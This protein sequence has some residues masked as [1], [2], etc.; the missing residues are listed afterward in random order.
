MI[1]D[2]P[3]I[4]LFKTHDNYYIYDVNT[5]MILSIQKDTYKYLIENKDK[6]YTSDI[7]INKEV[8][9]LLSKGFLSNKHASK[10]EHPTSELLEYYLNNRLNTITLQVTQQCNLRCSYCAYSGTYENRIH[11]DKSMNI[12]VARKGI[13][14]LVNNSSESPKIS[15]GFYGGEPL[16]RADF[17]KECV[18]YA[19][20]Q[21]EGK[22]VTFHMTTN[23]TLLSENIIDFLVENNFS[24]LISLDGPEEMHD[25]NR[26]FAANGKGTFKSIVNNIERFNKKYPEYAKKKISFNAVLDGCTDIKCMSGFLNDFDAIKDL[27]WNASLVTSQYSKQKID[28]QESYRIQSKYERF[29][30]LLYMIG[31]LPQKDVLRIFDRE[32]ARLSDS[33][34]SRSLTRSLS[35]KIHHGGPCI[36]GVRKLF[37]D[38]N[39]T[40]YPCERVSELSDVMKIGSINEGFNLEK[41]KRILNIGKLTEESCKDCWAFRFCYLCAT[42]A[43][44]GTE[45]SKEKKLANCNSVRFNAEEE[46]KNYCTLTEFGYNFEKASI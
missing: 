29:K 15:V 10:I 25:K 36:P 8:Q 46:L 37:M 30:Y 11:N 24:L 14:I 28:I 21:S 27:R 7:S 41:I 19:K 35:E 6:L 3:F 1:K 39:G 2:T 23:G 43:D 9:I 38:V 40:F 4:H 26:V 20:K 34:Y 12:D 31:R 33:M 17:I 16:L 18:H 44:E 5:N 42:Y 45:L 13:D 32:F 22:E